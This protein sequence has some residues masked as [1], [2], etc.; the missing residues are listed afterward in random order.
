MPFADALA[1]ALDEACAAQAP[2]LDPEA[3]RACLKG[4]L[5][6]LDPATRAEIGRASC[7]ERV[8]TDV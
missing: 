2:N 3:L 4:L 6:G 1:A 5:E 8:L 7:R